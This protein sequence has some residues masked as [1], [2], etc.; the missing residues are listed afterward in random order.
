MKRWE[1]VALVGVAV[2]IMTSAVAVVWA[3]RRIYQGLAAWAG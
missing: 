3:V 1:Y 2:L